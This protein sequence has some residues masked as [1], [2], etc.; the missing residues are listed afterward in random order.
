MV[1][2]IDDLESEREGSGLQSVGKMYKPR[3]ITKLNTPSDGKFR[4]R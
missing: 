2:L 4:K 3:G 1:D